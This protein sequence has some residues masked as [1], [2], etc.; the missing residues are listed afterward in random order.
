MFSLYGAADWASHRMLHARPGAHPFSALALHLS[1]LSWWIEMMTCIIPAL[2][3][4]AP[5]GAAGLGL[6]L[7]PVRL[8]R[9]MLWSVSFLELSSLIGGLWL[10]AS[11]ALSA[12]DRSSSCVFVQGRTVS[13]IG[14]HK[15]LKSARKIVEDCMHNIHPIYKWENPA[16]CTSF[17]PLSLPFWAAVVV[18]FRFLCLL[19]WALSA[20]LLSRQDHI[21]F[22]L[23]ITDPNVWY[24]CLKFVVLA[25]RSWWSNV[26]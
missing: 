15:G 25:S 12:T 6:T 24:A 11:R 9:I 5:K 18:A 21:S 16:L 2:W 3:K 22:N 14:E 20:W 17:R 19:G 26:S 8:L 7:P 23:I 10:Q 4:V 1:L 13:L